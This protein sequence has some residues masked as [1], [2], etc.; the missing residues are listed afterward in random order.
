MQMHLKP[1]YIFIHSQFYIL[2]TNDHLQVDYVYGHH[3]HPSTTYGNDS[4]DDGHHHHHASNDDMAWDAT[5]SQASGIFSFSILFLHY[6]T[7]ISK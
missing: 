6:L 4:H 7:I 5:V 2:F 3:H 1:R